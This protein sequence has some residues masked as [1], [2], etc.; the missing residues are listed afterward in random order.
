MKWAGELPRR[1]FVATALLDDLGCGFS[2]QPALLVAP[3][4]HHTDGDLG[5]CISPDTLVPLV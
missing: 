1:A 2:W 3:G 5:I 4:P